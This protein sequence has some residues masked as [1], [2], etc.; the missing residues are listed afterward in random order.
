MASDALTPIGKIIGVHG[1]KGTLKLYSYAESADVFRSDQP[2]FLHSADGDGR[3]VTIRWAKPF[4]RN[5]VLLGLESI[6]DRTRAETLV[7]LTL[8]VTQDSLPPLEE[9]TY[10]WKDLIGLSVYDEDGRCLGILKQILP[11][12]SNDVYVVENGDR[13]VLIPALKSVVLAVDLD[14]KTMTV[15]LPEGL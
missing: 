1:I 3:A 5:V 9:D 8:S 10:Y 15:A 13:E 4:K 14:G 6:E 12:G 2:A 7:G 11:T